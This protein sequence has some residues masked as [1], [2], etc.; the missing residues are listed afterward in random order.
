MEFLLSGGRDATITI[1][2]NQ[3][4]P[5]P[6]GEMMDPKTGRTEVRLVNIESFTY[7]SAY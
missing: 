6:F 4:V 2:R 7:R 3:V 5:I 1:Q